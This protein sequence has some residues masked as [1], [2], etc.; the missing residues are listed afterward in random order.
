MKTRRASWAVAILLAAG[1]WIT[2]G[3]TGSEGAGDSNTLAKITQ[4]DD[5][6][7]LEKVAGSLEEAAKVGAPR[8]LGSGPKFTRSAAYARLGVLGTPEAIAAI[9]R[10]EDAARKLPVRPDWESPHPCWHYGD[11]GQRAP[12]VEAV[13]K[14]GTT[15]ALVAF[16]GFGSRDLG[17]ITQ[18]A[19]QRSWS[20]PMLVLEPCRGTCTTL[21]S[22]W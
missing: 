13:A 12:L 14:D 2:M 6:A 16:N 20:R 3:T 4:S 21:S 1:V 19:G 22:S 9:H 18:K 10:L 17:L 5:V 8:Q 15:Y 7:Y 11:S